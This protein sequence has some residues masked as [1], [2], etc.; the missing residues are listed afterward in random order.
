MAILAL[1]VGGAAALAGALGLAAS[2]QGRR[3]ERRVADDARA[4]FAQPASAPAHQAPLATLPP[5]V[6]RYLEVSGAARHAPI[7]AVRVRH[8]GTFV[9]RIGGAPMPIRGVQYLTSDPPGFVWWGRVRPVRGLWI[10]AR[11]RTVAGEGN[12]LVRAESTFTLADARGP[13]LD[14]GALL[15]LLGEAVWMPTLF[16]DPRFVAWQPVDAATATA[17]LRVGG[18]E[19]S[20]T[21][22]FGAGGL[23]SHF[24]A[25]RFRDLGGGRSALT[26]FSGVCADYREVG[27]VQ[28]PFRL[29]ALWH[30]DSGPFPYAR[31]DVE[32]VEHGR[33]EPW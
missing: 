20:G 21:F 17:T 24:A 31:W 30:L 14:Q 10:D 18:R 13:E 7:L 5:P 22:H 29:T 27:G 8:G 19:V 23:P 28:V 3:F 33:A 6:R 12:M 16:R 1:T 26:P 11:D 4:L 25:R 2:A 15:R 32:A 9:A